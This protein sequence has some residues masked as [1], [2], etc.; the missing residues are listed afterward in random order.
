MAFTITC[1]EPGCTR[2]IRYTSI[3]KEVPLYC[4]CHRTETGRHSMTR[5]VGR[6]KVLDGI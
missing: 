5:Q 2:Q 4:E 6:T 1:S 3:D